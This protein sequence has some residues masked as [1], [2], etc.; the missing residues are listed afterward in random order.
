MTNTKETKSVSIED[1][2]WELLDDQISTTSTSV[3]DKSCKMTE[4]HNSISGSLHAENVQLRKLHRE[5]RRK[6]TEL[7]EEN[8]RV[9]HESLVNTE[10]DTK[11]FHRVQAECDH[12]KSAL[13]AAEENLADLSKLP[14]ENPN[15]RSEVSVSATA[16]RLATERA[17]WEI[18]VLNTALQQA[19]EK[20]VGFEKLQAEHERLTK[21]NIS[22]A[23]TLQQAEKD[24][25]SAAE[26]VRSLE[27]QLLMQSTHSKS[28]TDL[29][30]KTVAENSKLAKDNGRIIAENERLMKKLGKFKTEV[31]HGF[32]LAEKKP[33][34]GSKVEEMAKIFEKS[35]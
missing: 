8:A 21:D 13:L 19:E 26:R 33:L 31:E 22:I 6:I 25:F 29:L 24:L 3:S 11:R 18:R 17:R 5:A 14:H 30:E 34:K 32:G 35:L 20:L 10:A 15:H 7:Q 16:F 27:S 23:D 4:Y 1:E 28:V 12:Y 9:K 2:P